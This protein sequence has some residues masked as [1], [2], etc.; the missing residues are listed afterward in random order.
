VDS[1]KKSLITLGDA[2]V[3]YPNFLDV[4][5][6]GTLPVVALKVAIAPGRLLLYRTESTNGGQP[7]HPLVW[8]LA[9]STRLHLKGSGLGLHPIASQDSQILRKP[10]PRAAD[11]SPRKKLPV[12]VPVVGS[13]EARWAHPEILHHRQLPKTQTRGEPLDLQESTASRVSGG[14][15]SYII[16]PANRH[17]QPPDPLLPL[18]KWGDASL[19]CC[20]AI[21]LPLFRLPCLPLVRAVLRTQPHALTPSVMPGKSTFCHLFA[22]TDA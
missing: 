20:L 17:C 8:L 21:M 4:V 6:I 3:H 1:T 19:S 7:N 13:G 11:L 5:A 12:E 18:R 9:N 22:V 10:G 2:T 14:T 15:A 16:C